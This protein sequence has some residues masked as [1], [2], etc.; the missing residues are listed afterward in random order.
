MEKIRIGEGEF[1]IPREKKDVFTFPVG[2][3]IWPINPINKRFWEQR[4]LQGSINAIPLKTKD[5][6]QKRLQS[7]SLWEAISK[8]GVWSGRK[9]RR[10]YIVAGDYFGAYKKNAQRKP[11]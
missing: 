3:T 6:K 9:Q 10:F 1:P 4:T 2:T 7:L 11:K 5:D 8:S